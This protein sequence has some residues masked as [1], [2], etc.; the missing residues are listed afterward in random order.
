MKSEDY[1]IYLPEFFKNPLFCTPKCD[2]HGEAVI[3]NN[4]LITRINTKKIS[5]NPCN[6]PAP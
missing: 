5:E 2:L 4:P 6:L 1:L 3:E